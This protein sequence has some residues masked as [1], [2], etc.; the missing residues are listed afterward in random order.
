VAQ[1]QLEMFDYTSMCAGESWGSLKFRF[2]LTTSGGNNWQTV[3]DVMRLVGRV[4]ARMSVSGKRSTRTTDLSQF[5]FV[6]CPIGESDWARVV[7]TFPVA[8]DVF[9]QLATW[10][11]EG[12]KISF[13]INPGNDQTICSLTDKREASA[14]YGACLTAGADGWYDALRVCAFKYVV[15][16]N[17]SLS[18]AQRQPSPSARIS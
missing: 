14:S 16:L 2:A 11:G 4:E 5:Y 17:G 15:L 6:A 9:N 18:N 3:R 1:T 12:L 13:S 7:E 10:L 8:D